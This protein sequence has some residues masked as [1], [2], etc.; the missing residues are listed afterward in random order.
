MHSIMGM[1]A[2]PPSKKKKQSIIHVQGSEALRGLSVGLKVAVGLGL[3]LLLARCRA[4]WE[5]HFRAA[6]DW[7]PEKLEK[8]SSCSGV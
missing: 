8:S 2:N 6:S 3:Y 1:S 7:T 4:S 5:R